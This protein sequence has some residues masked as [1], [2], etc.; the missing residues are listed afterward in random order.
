VEVAKQ[1]GNAVPPPL[2]ACIADVIKDLLLG[3]SQA[4]QAA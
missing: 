3:S 2:A 4:K 1:I